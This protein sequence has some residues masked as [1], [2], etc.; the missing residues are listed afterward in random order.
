MKNQ[1]IATPKKVGGKE[2]KQQLKYIDWLVKPTPFS[3]GIAQ[4]PENDQKR[5]SA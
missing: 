5:P 1:R 3:Q 4:G 2:G